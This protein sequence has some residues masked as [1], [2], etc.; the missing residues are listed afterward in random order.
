VR[1]FLFLA[2]PMPAGLPSCG[3]ELVVLPSYD[4]VADFLGP[5]LGTSL[6]FAA[7]HKQVLQQ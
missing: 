7:C 2:A 5:L 4:C 6:T 1:N 3:V